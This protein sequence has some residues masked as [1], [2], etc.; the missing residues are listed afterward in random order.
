MESYLYD[1][2]YALE[3]THWW[4]RAK[5]HTVIS[6]IKQFF[7]RK[8]G[9]V[10][11]D[12]GCG[13]GKNL[14]TFASMGFTVRGID[15]SPK[16]VAYCKKRGVKNVSVGSAQHTKLA[17]SSVDVVTMLDV[18]EHVNEKSVIREVYRILKPGGIF[19]C[20]VPAKPS[21]WSGWDEVLH[22]KRRYTKD[23]L[24]R[25]MKQWF[26]ISSI[27]YRYLFLVLPVFLIRT[28]KTMKK[29][30]SY[31]SDFSFTNSFIN[32]VLYGMSL[33]DETI[34]SVASLPS[35]TSLFCVS[36]KP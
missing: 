12:I 2:L 35:G 36:I 4:H 34:S 16:A 26:T 3:E 6:Y 11:V 19:I 25:A 31:G 5:R 27:T 7:L 18:L 21:L 1:D 10:I 20:Y 15:I 13:T 29:H 22:H 32:T 14:E 30:T 9:G 33:I 24:M 17:T 23:S 28:S 8:K